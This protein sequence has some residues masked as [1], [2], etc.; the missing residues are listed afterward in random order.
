MSKINKLQAELKKLQAE[1]EKILI[2]KYKYIIGK[3][4]RQPD[5]YYEKITNILRIETNELYTII[6][7]DC[8]SVC[9]DTEGDDYNEAPIISLNGWGSIPIGSIEKRIISDE[10]FNQIFNDCVELFKMKIS[11]Q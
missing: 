3:C 11:N 4:V 7:Y 9:Y 10:K 6:V 8:V 2:D 1:E 5:S